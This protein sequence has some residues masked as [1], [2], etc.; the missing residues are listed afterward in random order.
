MP[1]D[2][3]DNIKRNDYKLTQPRLK[4]LRC[5]QNNQKPQTPQE[6]HLSCRKQGI[7]LVTVYRTLELFQRIG[8]V[9]RE[10]IFRETRY[11]LD[12]NEHHHIACRKCLT[13][14]CIPCKMEF[15]KIKGFSNIQHFLTLTGIC[16]QCSS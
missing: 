1:M 4:I 15:S 14:K 12:Q 2:F 5:L 9:H 13:I 16:K 6:I 11:Y 8:I 3:V 7:D 10:E